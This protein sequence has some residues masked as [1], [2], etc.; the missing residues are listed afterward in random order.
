[1]GKLFKSDSQIESLTKRLDSL[2]SEQHKAATEAGAAQAQA[3]AAVQEQLDAAQR[4]EY[5]KRSRMHT[6]AEQAQVRRDYDETLKA[7]VEVT[8]E[9]RDLLAALTERR[10]Q[11][12]ELGIIPAQDFTSGLA[13][14]IAQTFYAWD[15]H[16][17]ELTGAP[18]RPNDSARTFG[19]ANHSLRATKH[20]W[21][22]IAQ[23][24]R[25]FGATGK[26]DVPAAYSNFTRPRHRDQAS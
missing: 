24:L 2:K 15:R 6:K 11:C 8:G 3:I 14:M 21:R 22:S 25:T 5:R 23:W 17:A 12:A 1:M 9:L 26:G 18:P 13:T 20:C 19:S 4:A 7:V 16:R 10:K